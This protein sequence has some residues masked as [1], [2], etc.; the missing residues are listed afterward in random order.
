MLQYE[1]TGR[2][3]PSALRAIA[4]D[5]GRIERDWWRGAIGLDASDEGRPSI[6]TGGT[7]LFHKSGIPDA[8]DLFMA[9]A[10]AAFILGRLAGWSK[11]HKIKWHVRMNDEDWG[12]VDP[13]GLTKPLIEQMGK[14][15][16]RLRIFPSGR[17][18]WFIPE[19]RRAELLARHASR[20]DV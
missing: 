11:T 16:H 10:D 1:S 9:F 8:D 17:D 15:A 4:D 18:T 6:L 5:I 13:G 20:K 19:E 3:N 14:W 12:A 7:P 2:V